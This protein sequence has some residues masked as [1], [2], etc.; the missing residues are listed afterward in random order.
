MSCLPI[1]TIAAL[2]AIYFSKAR[3][4]STAS[5]PL[6]SGDR[7]FELARSLLSHFASIGR[8]ERPLFAAF[9]T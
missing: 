7:V 1:D 9:H 5:S 2:P 3:L 6:F 8:G 4:A